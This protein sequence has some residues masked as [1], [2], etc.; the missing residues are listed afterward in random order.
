MKEITGQVIYMGPHVRHLGLGYGMIFRDGIF[1]HLYDHIARCPALGELFVPIAQCAAVRKELNF[2]YSHNL[3]GT[4]GSYVVFYRE[5]QKW[6]A[7]PAD[8]QTPTPASGITLET[9]PCQT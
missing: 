6:L 5:V 3:R 7:S 9:Q 1:P 4:T 8:Q 2:D